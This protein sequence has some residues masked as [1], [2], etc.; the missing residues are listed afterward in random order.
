MPHL[1]HFART[2][3]VASVVCLLAAIPLTAAEVIVDNT[4]A[5]FSVL[6]GTWSTR[7]DGT[8]E[9]GTNYAR[10]RT[11][12]S[13]SGQ[14]QWQ[15]TIPSA[16]DYEVFVWYP[17]G[18][19]TH[20]TDA[21]Y[22]VYYNGGNQAVTVNQTINFSQWVSLGTYTFAAGSSTNG[23]VT[24]T[25]QAGTRNLYVFADAVRFYNT[26]PVNLTMAVSPGGAGSTSPTIGGPDRKS[27]V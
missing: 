8:G 24:L 6:S 11:A 3:F 26:A 21:R 19:G 25:N 22:T 7:T 13:A 4:D 16:G 10:A 2:A 14:V 18:D 5:G 27:V 23:R 1:C 15:P 12:T 20:I 9:Y 17:S